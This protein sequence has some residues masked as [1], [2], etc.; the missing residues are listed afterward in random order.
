MEREKNYLIGVTATLIALI[1]LGSASF[2]YSSI[3]ILQNSLNEAFFELAYLGVHLIMLVTALVF[4]LK[5]CKAGES[6]IMRNLMF[7]DR[8][9]SRTSFVVSLV[10]SILFFGLGLYSGLMFFG[11]VPLLFHFNQVLLLVLFN[12]SIS[13]ALVSLDF[14]F[15]PKFA[16]RSF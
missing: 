4:S 10:L 15:F 5:A 1:L 3:I 11:A 12:V 9:A 6:Y 2:V 14:S 16:R 7:S 8:G 13:V